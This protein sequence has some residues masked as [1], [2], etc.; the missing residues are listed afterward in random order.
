MRKGA[1]KKPGTQL[2]QNKNRTLG[3][4]IRGIN[5]N[6]EI[7]QNEQSEAISVTDKLNKKT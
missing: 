3:K 5:D 7:I 4:K 2:Q 6:D 1:Q